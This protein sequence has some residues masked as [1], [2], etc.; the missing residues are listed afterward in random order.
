MQLKNL[1]AEH[2]ESVRLVYS[3]YGH[4]ATPISERTTVLLALEHGEP[5]VNDVADAIADEYQLFDGADGTKKLIKKKK[6]KQPIKRQLKGHSTSLRPV[7]PS[8]PSASPAGK[9]SP[10]L[11]RINEKMGIKP[12]I[13]SFAS[14]AQPT[15]SLA[16]PP[17]QSRPQTEVDRLVKPAVKNVFESAL[18][19]AREA[20]T[21]YAD[22][23]NAGKMVPVI[24]SAVELEA[25][26]TKKQQ[27]KTLMI[28]GVISAVLIIALL[29]AVLRKPSKTLI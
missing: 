23:K 15:P 1:I 10:V 8:I 17:L 25:T 19:Y 21:I 24:P 13:P 29:I 20:V 2:P 3:K 11:S 26:R 27:N 6:T 22:A 14:I 12:G 4:R 7:G 28:A 16:T 9:L 5:F 18:N